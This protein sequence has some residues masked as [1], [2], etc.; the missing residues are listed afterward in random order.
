VRVTEN[1][2]LGALALSQNKRFWKLI[3]A[4]IAHGEK[5]GLVDLAAL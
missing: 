4:A 5:E 3:D 1:T 2:D